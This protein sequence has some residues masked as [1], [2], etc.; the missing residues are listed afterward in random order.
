MDHDYSGFFDHACNH[1]SHYLDTVIDGLEVLKVGEKP[2]TKDDGNI[3]SVFKKPSMIHSFTALYFD[4]FRPR[5]YYGKADGIPIIFDS[6]YTHT[7][8]PFASDFIGSITPVNKSMNGLGAAVNVVGEGIIGWSFR[9]NYGVKRKI[10]VKAYLVSASKVRLFSPQAYFIQKNDSSFSMDKD[11]ILFHFINGGTL[12]FRHASSSLPIAY[13]SIVKT[14]NASEY[15]ASTG[16][17]N[18]TKAQEELLLWHFILVHYNIQNTQ[19]LITSSG[20]ET[21]PIL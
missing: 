7:L 10:Q 5:G 6:G 20:V 19:Q 18:I 11:E 1:Y 4:L 8:T 12:T 2:K 13:D 15:L 21:E 14:P 9:D 3:I 16:R 17:T